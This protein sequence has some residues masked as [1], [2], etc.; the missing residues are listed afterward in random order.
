MEATFSVHGTM[1]ANPNL[2]LQAGQLLP[3]KLLCPGMLR[4]AASREAVA[5]KT[6]PREVVARKT[7]SG[8][9]VTG[10]AGS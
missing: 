3:V 2:A 4:D 7:G 10:K 6:G 1:T 8:E 9:S 5:R